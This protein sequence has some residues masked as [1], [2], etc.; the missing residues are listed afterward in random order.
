MVTVK[1]LPEGTTESLMK[2]AAHF[3]S[4]L[5]MHSST[6]LFSL[7]SRTFRW[8]W[9]IAWMEGV[10]FS[11]AKAVAVVPFRGP[12]FITETVGAR[13]WISNGLLLTSKPWWFTW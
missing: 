7:S 10:D 13:L 11:D 1:L 4:S 6:V 2:F 8:T 9:Y 12:L 5:A 3:S